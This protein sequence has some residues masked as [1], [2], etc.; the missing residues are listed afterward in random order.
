MVPYL[1]AKQFHF[2]VPHISYLKKKVPP[3]SSPPSITI[4]NYVLSNDR[5][6]QSRGKLT[7]HMLNH[8]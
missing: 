2:H 3:T 5:S 6:N 4:A 7:M 1:L 8:V